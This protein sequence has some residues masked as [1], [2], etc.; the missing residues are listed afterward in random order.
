MIFCFGLSH[1]TA[2]VEL[3]ERVAVPA[4]EVPEAVQQLT[5]LAGVGEAVVVS[6]CNRVEIYATAN[7]TEA[8]V[9]VQEWIRQRFGLTDIAAFFHHLSNDAARHLF[10]VVSGLESMVLGETEIFG[11]VKDA[12]AAAKDAGGT[13]R[14]LN[15]LFQ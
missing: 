10:S 14:I 4:K 1:A 3:R 8:V 13:A 6:T 2:P 7:S 15:K 5:A 9:S 12:Y 11:Q